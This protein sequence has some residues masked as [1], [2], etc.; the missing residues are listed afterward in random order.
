MNIDEVKP[1]RQNRTLTLHLGNTLAEYKTAYLTQEG[2]TRQHF[3]IDVH[4]ERGV[5]YLQIGWC[6]LRLALN[7]AS[8]FLLCFGVTSGE[9]SPIVTF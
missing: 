1:K 4:W 9:K 5:S 8:G 7:R 6:W 2:I 3:Q